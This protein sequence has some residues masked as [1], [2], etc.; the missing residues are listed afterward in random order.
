MDGETATAGKA[1]SLGQFLEVERR[2]GGAHGR[3]RAPVT[4]ELVDGVPECQPAVESET[5]S[6]FSNGCIAPAAPPQGVGAD[7]SERLESNEGKHSRE[8]CHA[9]VYGIPLRFSCMGGCSL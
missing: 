6:L 7:A 4:Y 8:L 5:N 3:D 2:A 9:N 1:P